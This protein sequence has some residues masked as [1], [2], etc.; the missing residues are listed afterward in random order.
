VADYSRDDAYLIEYAFNELGS[1]HGL[2]VV[3]NGRDVINYLNGAG[4]YFDRRKFKL[5]DVLLMELNLPFINGFEVLTWLRTQPHLNPL[6]VVILTDW[7]FVEDIDK[8][9]DL[10]AHS[11]FIKTPN[12]A[13]VVQHCL[14]LQ[15]YSEDLKAGKDGTK[16]AR[17]W[18]RKELLS[19]FPLG[20]H[21][22]SC[23]PCAA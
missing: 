6:P 10:G 16:P 21:K 22:K 7:N 12:F 14:S 20:E 4:P 23:L 9:C 13:D 3:R 5:P 18:P 2:S 17:I 8:A 11:I 19:P 15:R 1:G